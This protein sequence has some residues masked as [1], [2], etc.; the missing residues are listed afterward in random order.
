MSLIDSHCHIDSEKFDADREAVI[1]R[2]LAAGVKHMVVIGS[3]GGPP[4]LEAG[5]R[6]A[7]RHESC[8]ATVCVHPHDAA[9]ATPEVYR[10][11]EELVKHPKVVA[12]GETGLD[13]HYD[14]A[15][16]EVQRAVFIEQLRL[17]RDA[18]KPIVIHTREAWADTIAVLREYWAPAGIVGIMHCFSGGPA[19][20]E[21]ALALGFYLSFGGILTFPKSTAIQE[22]AARV[23]IRQEGANVVSGAGVNPRRQPDEIS[24][25]RE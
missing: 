13:Y 10:R 1:E 8:Y 22:A 17:A 19:E 4:D 2:A 20:A 3:G 21:E 5:I 9:K 16:R 14:F 11:L 25:R 12:V 18:R 15:P 6:L 24:E 7:D 23:V